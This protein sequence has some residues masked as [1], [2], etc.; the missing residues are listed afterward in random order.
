MSKHEIF[1]ESFYFSIH[2][3]FKSTY[4]QYGILFGYVLYLTWHKQK[5]NDNNIDTED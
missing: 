2:S 5:I 1:K 4:R 3:N